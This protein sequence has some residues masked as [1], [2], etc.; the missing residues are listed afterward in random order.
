MFDGDDDHPATGCLHDVRLREQFQR[1][2][3]DDTRH[4]DWRRLVSTQRLA[5]HRVC[6]SSHG[7]DGVLPSV[8]VR[9]WTAVAYTFVAAISWGEIELL[10]RL[11][12]RNHGDLDFVL[13]N[14]QG[15]L[16]GT[17]VW[18]NFQQ[19]FLGPWCV[20]VLDAVTGDRTVSLEYF[21]AATAVAANVL[22]FE[23]MSRRAGN[24]LRPLWAVVALAAVRV[25]LAYKLEYPWDGLNVL[26]FLTFGDFAARGRPLLSLA[27]LLVAGTLNHEAVLYV[28]LWYLIAAFDAPASRKRSALDAVAVLA[29]MSV[30][31][32]ALRELYY[33]GRPPSRDVVEAS[34]PLVGNPL[35]VSH[36]L[37]CLLVHDWRLG[38]LV[39]VGFVV[40]AVLF[41]AL[42]TLRVHRASALWSLC[43]LA[44]ILCFGYVN[45]TRLYLPLAAFWLSRLGPTGRTHAARV[46]TDV[47]GVQVAT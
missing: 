36:N 22:L 4:A 1:T 7:D 40:A 26:L 13:R 47:H 24:V 19:R 14:V 8:G 18:K 25:V 11:V 27:P 37:R 5:L 29:T 46:M 20:A 44:S 34:T 15:I 39:S 30:S 38:A 9:V 17:P 33:V 32:F 35:H 6:D 23:L 16:H 10:H 28:P 21:L 12:F 42:W 2:E 31:I 3:T 45:E 43:V 41:V